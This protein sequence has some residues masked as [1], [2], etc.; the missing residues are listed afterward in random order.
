MNI[1]QINRN[2][3]KGGAAVVSKRL[4]DGLNELEGVCSNILCRN[5][6]GSSDAGVY[7]LYPKLTGRIKSVIVDRFEQITGC[8][9]LFQKNFKN[10]CE[11][12]IFKD[13]DIVH[14]HITHGGYID[15]NFLVDVAKHKPVVWTFHD[16]WAL[17]GRCAHSYECE[18]WITGCGQCPNTLTYPTQY[19]D[20]SHYLWELKKKLYENINV[21]IISPSNWLNSKI[22]KSF[23]N[24][25]DHRVIPNSVDLSVFHY[26]KDNSENIRLDLNIPQNTKIF[27]FVAH[28]GVSNSYKGFELLNE[29]FCELKKAGSNLYLLVIGGN[30][31]GSLDYLGINGQSVGVVDDNNLL[32]DYYTAA[33][34]YIISSVQENLPLTIIESLACGTPVIA[35][36][37]GGI[38]EMIEHMVTGY[39]ADKISI[40]NLIEGIKWAL[41]I[42][43]LK[44][45]IL[46]MIL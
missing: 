30:E 31:E 46:P 43:L 14:F 42:N 37:V 6:M 8:Q 27:L 5:S 10:I 4:H 41:Q 29:A 45:I 20:R 33:D 16:M 28:G 23:I 39:L 11:L 24:H 44:A 3:S 7:E 34:Y 13:A 19:F 12:K 26:N 32:A 36:D 18:K 25:W 40:K 1:L 9:Y 35:F 17:T 21:N 22:D 15:Q 38:S 2:Y